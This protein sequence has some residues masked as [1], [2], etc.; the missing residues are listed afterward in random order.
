MTG[1]YTLCDSESLL[2]SQSQV[3]LFFFSE[4]YHTQFMVQVI[5]TKAL[6]V[7]EWFHSEGTVLLIS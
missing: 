7:E 1:R 5:L 2:S 3:M 6:H 4:K